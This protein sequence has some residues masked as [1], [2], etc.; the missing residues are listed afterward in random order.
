MSDDTSPQD[1]EIPTPLSY[2]LTIEEI[3]A[4]FEDKWNPQKCEC[5]GHDQWHVNLEY[6]FA[7]LP[8]SEGKR[9]GTLS[10]KVYICT[11]FICTTCGNT[12]LF[13]A[14]LIRHWLE[15]NGSK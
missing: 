12:K 11:Y 8:V 5:C 6:P 1:Q 14:P 13:S 9:L 15:E 10:A 3:N 7:V 4:F 2:S